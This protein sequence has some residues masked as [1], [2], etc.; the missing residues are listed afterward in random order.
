MSEAFAAQLEALDPP[1]R[2][3][4]AGTTRMTLCVS[5]GISF[6]R[7]PSLTDLIST[8]I[9][10]LPHEER[11]EQLFSRYRDE[12]HFVPA[13]RESGGA[14]PEHLTLDEF[15]D[16]PEDSK[17]SACKQMS[18]VYGDV[19]QELIESFGDKRN[20]LTALDF[21]RFQHGA[22]DAAHYY[23]AFLYIEERIN[24]VV[25][26]NW[27]CLIEK[28][29]RLVGRSTALQIILDEASW[30]RRNEAPVGKL[31]KIHGCA[32]QYPDQ[33]QHIVLTSADVDR[34]TATEWVR[35]MA[36]DFLNGLV[37]FCG[38]SARDS[39][40]N[41][42]VRSIE[43]MRRRAEVVPANYYVSQEDPIRTRAFD[44]L[45]HNDATHHIHLNANDLFCSVYFGWLRA[46]LREVVTSAQSRTRIERPFR[47]SDSDW[48][49]AVGRINQLVE[50]E[51]SRMLDRVIGVPT[52]RRWDDSSFNLPIHLSALRTLFLDGKVEERDSYHN[53]RFGDVT[54]DVVLL[55]IL[56]T[57]LDIV[58]DAEY[59]HLELSRGY[60][61]LTLT[62]SRTGATRQI[63]F[64][65]GPYVHTAYGILM[66]YLTEI[67]AAVEGGI[68]PEIVVI[69]CEGYEV[70]DNAESLAPASVTDK[71]LQGSQKA[72]TTF[73]EPDRI[74][75]AQ[76]LGELKTA[77]QDSLELA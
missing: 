41:V 13:I 24:R 50:V 72:I 36:H 67:D 65:R 26:L 42:S 10:A 31:V 17:R 55:V 48:D 1:L 27:D 4:Y 51:L 34:V 43:E 6:G 45:I 38:Y 47:W 3:F 46:R 8:A 49:V 23:L 71:Q 39:S 25:S 2:G 40:V 22:P 66:A 9:A 77:L 12:F 20:L 64:Y 5:S 21:Q 44:T 19:F 75:R 15:R 62:D 28:A 35:E 63:I 11:S 58:S 16:L 57:L 29:V 61:G 30:I 73:I 74:L 37:I 54:R 60:C 70:G 18:L 32:T 76:N 53:L 33:C 14:C 56:A 7:M 69:P 59:L 68:A 52:A